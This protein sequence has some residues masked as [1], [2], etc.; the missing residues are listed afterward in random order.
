VSAASAPSVA[1]TG[2]GCLT[3]LGGDT[4]TTWRA[5]CEGRTARAPLT[6]IAVEGCR[7]TEGAEAK[8]P[9]WP[10][11]PE[12]KLRHLSR[13][14]RLAL[15]A[16]REALDNAGLLDATGRCTLPRLEM[17]VSTTACGIETTT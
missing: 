2:I 15:P 16:V 17:S 13:A 9:A 14:T 12:K 11:W 7:V 10:P 5:V 6:A 3:A 8:L 1:V 4:T